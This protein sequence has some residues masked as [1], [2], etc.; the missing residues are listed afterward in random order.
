MFLATY[1][2]RAFLAGIGGFDVSSDEFKMI[3]REF[4]DKVEREGL[5]RIRKYWYIPKIER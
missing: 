2:S 4:V 5:V 3:M 1:P